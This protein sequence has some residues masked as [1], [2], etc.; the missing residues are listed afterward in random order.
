VS[1]NSSAVTDG[2]GV[3]RLQSP[4]SRNRG[5]FVFTVTGVTLSGYS[6]QAGSNIETSDSITR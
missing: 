4:S 6:Y 5:T 1:G 2:N 3:A